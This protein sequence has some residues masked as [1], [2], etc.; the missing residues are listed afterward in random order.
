MGGTLVAWD[1]LHSIVLAKVCRGFSQSLEGNG[2]TA[3]QIN[4]RLL[5]SQ[6]SKLKMRKTR[7]IIQCLKLGL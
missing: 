4:K 3:C 7:F 5:T 2:A 6:R 1:Q